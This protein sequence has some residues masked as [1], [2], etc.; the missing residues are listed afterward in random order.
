MT[1]YF[2]TLRANSRKYK[3][4]NAYLVI[5]YSW[6]ETTSDTKKTLQMTKDHFQVCG[7]KFD[8]HTLKASSH[9]GCAMCNLFFPF[10]NTY[11]FK[12]L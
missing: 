11:P 12:F 8:K 4:K 2:L 10:S 5:N 1:I 7:K 9:N 3:T 6:Y